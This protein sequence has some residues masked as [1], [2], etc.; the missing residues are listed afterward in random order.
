MAKLNYEIIFYNI[1]MTFYHI[2]ITFIVRNY[3]WVNEFKMFSLFWVNNP[4]NTIHIPEYDDQTV[5]SEGNERLV[6]MWHNCD[7]QTTT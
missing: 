4:F 7:T 2:F 5:K 1:I 6:K 3:K